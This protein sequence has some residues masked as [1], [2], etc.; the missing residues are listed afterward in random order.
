MKMVKSLILGSAAG[1]VRM[2]GA[3]SVDLPRQG[4]SGRVREDLLPLRCWFLHSGHRRLHRAR[5]LPAHRHHVQW[6]RLPGGLVW[7]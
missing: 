3:L 7:R 5:W 1:L 6:S 4:Q 2:S